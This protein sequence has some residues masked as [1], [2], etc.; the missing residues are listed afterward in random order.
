[1]LSKKKRYYPGQTSSWTTQPAHEQLQTH[2]RSLAERALPSKTIE[3][4]VGLRRAYDA[5]E[6]IYVRGDT[7]YTAGT[8]IS[9]FGENFRDMYDDLKIPLGGTKSTHRYQQLQQALAAN[10]Q[11]KHLV[12]HSLGGSVILEA[13]KLRP[14]L[15]TTTYGAPV[16]DIMPKTLLEQAPSRFANRWD[17]IAMLDSKA[18]VGNNGLSNPHSFEGFD[19]TSSTDGRPGVENPDGSISLYE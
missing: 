15:S 13:A 3:D 17:P 11:V 12:G 9:R 2:L 14:D 5:P 10:P 4:R 1:M 7:L 16:F 8:Q 19:H 18:Q 6:S